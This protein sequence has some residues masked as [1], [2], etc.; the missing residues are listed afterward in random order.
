MEVLKLF[1]SKK[2]TIFGQ[3]EGEARI[4]GPSYI[5]NMSL[6]GDNVTLGYPVRRKILSLDR[7]NLESYDSVSTGSR[8]GNSCIIRSNTI[9][10]ENVELGDKVETGHGVMIREGTS[11]GAG[12]RIGTHSVIDGNV[13]I[14]CNTN[15]QTGVYLPPG[16]VIGSGIFLGP[17]VTVTN[18]R[19]PPTPKVSG[20]TVEDD[21]IIGCRAVLIAGVRIGRR[22]VVAA[23]AVVTK[24][25]APETVVM[26]VPARAAMCR[27]DYDKKQKKFL[28][29]K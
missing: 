12:T 23:G 14:G 3:I 21:A 18:D 17:Y 19:Y 7:K 2:A 9:I 13:K 22:A 28:E 24:D 15:I 10:Y 8:I 16:T 6:I 25:V 5:G 11:V 29:E 4:F 26:G 1:I 20:V 27:E